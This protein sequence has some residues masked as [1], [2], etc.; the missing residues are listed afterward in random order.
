MQTTSFKKLIETYIN[1]WKANDIDLICQP[2]SHNCTII[3]SH[4]PTYHGIKDVKEWVASWIAGK[5]KVNKWDIVSLVATKNTAVFEWLFVFSSPKM[6]KRSIEG[7]SLVK[8]RKNK[9][10]YWREYRTTKPLYNWNE[11]KKLN[12]Y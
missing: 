5:Y 6:L 4:G 9:I 2:L 3:E 8:F 10:V 7:I 1:G 12:T 11:S